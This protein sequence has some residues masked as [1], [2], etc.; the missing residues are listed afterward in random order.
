MTNQPNT[1]A[2]NDEPSWEAC[3]PGLLVSM[4]ENLSTAKRRKQTLRSVALSSVVLLA[5]GALV[6]RSISAD[7]K[8]G[9]IYCSQCKPHFA[10]YSA[11]LESKPLESESLSPDLIEQLRLH[12]AGCKRCRGKFS[13]T[14][15][16][17]LASG[18]LDGRKLNAAYSIA[19]QASAFGSNQ[20]AATARRWY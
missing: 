17:L 1:A 15:P 6:L 11:H 19:L 13:E 5:C 8:V 4:A 16:G 9:G 7:H 2:Y 12:L 14:Y 10:A 20:F 18:S 3:S